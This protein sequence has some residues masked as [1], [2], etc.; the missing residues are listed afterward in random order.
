MEC[1]GSG[2]QRFIFKDQTRRYKPLPK[3]RKIST[4]P[5]SNQTNLRPCYSPSNNQD[6]LT[7]AFID[8]VRIS[9]NLKYSLSWAYG[10]FLA[11]VPKR[12]G[13]NKAL[14]A[15][16]RALIASHLC[17]S[18]PGRI[19]SCQALSEYTKAIRV[20]RLSLDDPAEACSAS[21]LCAVNILLITQA[22]SILRIGL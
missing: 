7:L 5:S 11:D 1:V 13:T 10:S 2:Q 9:A 14:D 19:I 17:F 8:A 16:S 3:E 6:Q 12:L 22:S 21:T 15:A 20:L 18:T 4:N